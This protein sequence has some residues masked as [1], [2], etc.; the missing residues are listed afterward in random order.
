MKYAFMTGGA[1]GLGGQA[2]RLL[3]DKGWT[4]FAADIDQAALDK[5]NYQNIIPVQVDITKIESIERARDIVRQY[6]KGLDAVIN[7]AGMFNFTS[8]VENDPKIM[9]RVLS[10]NV[11]GMINVNYVMFPL[12]CEAK[13]RIINISSEIGWLKPQPFTSPYS[14]S[15]HA[16][17]TYTDAL[18]RELQFIGIKVIKIQPGSF[19]SDM[20]NA[21]EETFERLINETSLYKNN[22]R[23]LQF[24]MTNE[25]KHANDPIYLSGVVLKACT[26]KRPKINYRVKN[27]FK[28]KLLNILPDTIIDKIYKMVIK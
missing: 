13:G 8:L 18:R 20:H 21:A 22:L 10:V 2:C 15:K 4:V 25:L 9:E 12:I 23:S 3:A 19:R 24:I 26:A 1:G 28:L 7:F 27:S 14:V 17:D 5:I 16:V 11:M 6:T